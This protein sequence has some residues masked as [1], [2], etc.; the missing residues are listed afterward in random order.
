MEATKPSQED[1]IVAIATPPGDSGLAVLRLSGNQAFQLVDQCFTPV[2]KNA[3]RPS[4][5]TSHTGH[6]GLIQDTDRVLDEVMVSVFEPPRTFTREPVVE[7][8]TH[9]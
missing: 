3:R 5:S 8:S 4:E 9:G 2:G 1:T 6:Y 7:I